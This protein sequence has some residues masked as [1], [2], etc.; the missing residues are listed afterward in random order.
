MVGGKIIPCQKRR[1]FIKQEKV[2]VKL[3][4][5]LVESSKSNGADCYDDVML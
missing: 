2:K 3:L 4:S 5:T 1:L